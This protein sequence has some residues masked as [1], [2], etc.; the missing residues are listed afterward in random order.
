MKKTIVIGVVSALFSSLS[1]AAACTATATTSAVAAATGVITAGEMCVCDGGAAQTTAYN[2]GSGMVVAT[3]V[4]TKSGFI[5]Q[6]SSNTVVATNEVSGTLFV[7]AG[8]SRKGNQTVAGSSAGGAVTASGQCASTGC[9]G[10]N[11]T[12]AIGTVDGS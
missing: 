11:V 5:I 10:A 7:V 2:G 3:P 8:G 12:T 9:T 6:C 4:F 1:F